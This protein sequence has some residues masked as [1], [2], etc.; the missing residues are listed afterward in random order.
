MST[1]LVIGASSGIGEAVARRLVAAGW[2]V[3]G[4]ARRP[5][6]VAVERY[7]HIVADVRAPDYRD[8]LRAALDRFA[9]L[10][11]CVYATGIGHLLDP[12]SFAHEADVFATNL[13]GAVATAE[14]VV[15]RM[16]ARGAGHF[17]GLSSQADRL[18]TSDSPSYSASKAGLSSYLEGLALACRRRGVAV[19]NLRLGFVDT[20]MSRDQPIRP[21]LISADRAAAVVERC[22]RR[23]PIRLTVPRRMAALVWLL[24]LGARLRIWLS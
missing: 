18:I 2:T 14:L 4:M 15:P 3:I 17:I 12:T 10:D 5:A 6:A 7:H 16:V 1:A 23:R 11:L 19:T 8:V 9:P 21:F 24:G 22:L 20:A 13:T